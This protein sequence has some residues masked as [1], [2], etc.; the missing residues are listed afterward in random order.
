MTIQ[1]MGLCRPQPP[2][3]YTTAFFDA[4]IK[5]MFAANLPEPVAITAENHR[6]ARLERTN[7]N[8]FYLVHAGKAS[9]FY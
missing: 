7:H 4:M 6:E 1:P 9:N 8:L 2:A 3:S 5:P